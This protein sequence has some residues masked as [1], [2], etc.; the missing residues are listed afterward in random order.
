MAAPRSPADGRGRTPEGAAPSQLISQSCSSQTQRSGRDDLDVDLG[1]NLGVQTHGRLVGAQGLDRRAQL[2]AALVDLGATGSLDRGC[3]VGRGDG[4]EETTGVAGADG[5]T[6]LDALELGLHSVGL[7][8][9][10]DLVDLASTTDLLDVLLATLGPADSELPRDQVVAS[11][12]VL[13]VDDVARGTEAGD[14]VGEDDLHLS[15]TLPLSRGGGVG[16]QRHLTAVL[17]SRGDV[18]LVL[19]AVAGHAAGTD[20]AAV[21]NEL[22]QHVR[23]LVVH[24]RD[25]V[26]AE[27]ADLLLRL[28]HRRLRHGVSPV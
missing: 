22:P 16:Q 3:D 15:V 24:V 2:D 9:G 11:V 12:T 1:G 26:L 10:L 6:D 4:T 28:A 23:V 21:G 19:R 27:S 20:L 5:Q 25:L 7:L 13:D 18:T 17:H 14:L 8:D